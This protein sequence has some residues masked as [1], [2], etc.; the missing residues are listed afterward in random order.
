MIIHC[1]CVRACVHA[2]VCAHA[3]SAFYHLFPH[4]VCVRACVCA[5]VRVCVHMLCQPSTT[6]SLIAGDS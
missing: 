5:C 6:Y 1:V 2:R 4:C 3:V